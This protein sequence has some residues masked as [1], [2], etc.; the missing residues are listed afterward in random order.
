MLEPVA[1]VVLNTVLCGRSALEHAVPLHSVS[2]ITK[3]PASRPL[4]A[5]FFNPQPRR[6]VWKGKERALDETE[7]DT[8]LFDPREWTVGAGRALFPSNRRSRVLMTGSTRARVYKCPSFQKT[9]RSSSV[10]RQTSHSRLPPSRLLSHPVHSHSHSGHQ[11]RQASHIAD[12]QISE[13]PS[14]SIAVED[15]RRMMAKPE[16]SFDLNASLAAYETVES[17]Q[18]ASQ[19]TVHELVLLLERSLEH[20]EQHYGDMTPLDTLRDWG[21]RLVRIATALEHRIALHS[22][23]NYR[24]L[25]ALSRAHALMGD[26]EEA[27][28]VTKWMEK[29]LVEPEDRWR[30]VHVFRSLALAIHRYHDSARVLQLVASNWTAMGS[31]LSRWSSLNLHGKIAVHGRGFR[32][33]VQRIAS[34][35][36]NPVALLA[37]MAMTDADANHRRILGEVLIESYSYNHLP[38]S[39][40]DVHRELERQNIHIFLNLQLALVRSLVQERRMGPAKHL[41]ASIHEKSTFKYYLQTGLYLFGHVGDTIR[42]EKYYGRLSEQDWVNEE[43]VAMLMQAYATRGDSEK[44]K[45]LFDEFFPQDSQNNTRLNKPK[46]FHYS[47][48]IYS[49]ARKGDITGLNRWMDE[50]GEQSLEPDLHIYTML[51]QAF[52]SRGDLNSVATVL[53]RMRASGHPPD[54]VTYVSLISLLAHRRD[55]LGAESMYKRAIREGIVPSIPMVSALLNAHVEAGSW[56]GAIKIFDWI[57]TRPGPKIRLTIDIYNTVLKAYVLVGAPFRL[58]NRLFLRIE[59]AGDVTGVRPDAYSYAMLIQ[60]ACDAGRLD[61]AREIFEEIHERASIWESN[62]HVNVY[63]MTILMA[64]HLR[65]RD[66]T[67][68]RKI[69]DE[70]VERGITAD[71]TAYSVLL[72]SFVKGR[73]EAG[74][75][76][77]EDYIKSIILPK[78]ERPFL[79]PQYAGRLRAVTAL[80]HIYGPLLNAYARLERSEDVERTLQD[81][82]EKGGEVTLGMQTSLMDVYRRIGNYDGVEV[83]WRRIWE[84]GLDDIRQ[85]LLDDFK[86]E[87]N[88]DLSIDRLRTNLLCIPLSIYVDAMSSAGKHME[89]AAVWK[90]FQNNGLY[91]DSHNWNHLLVALLRAGEPYRAFQVAERVILPYQRHALRVKL[92]RDPNPSSPLYFEE[93]EPEEIEEVMEITTDIRTQLPKGRERMHRRNDRRLHGMLELDYESD[94]FGE[95][96]ADP[97]HKLYQI[98]PAWNVWRIHPVG[99]Q[100]LVWAYNSL[101]H[102]R[103]I[104]ALGDNSRELDPNEEWDMAEELLRKIAEDCPETI[105]FIRRASRRLRRKLG[106]RVYTTRLNSFGEPKEQRLAVG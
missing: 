75:K 43:D 15:F 61:I 106:E 4:A 73:S 65:R 36:Q 45:Q 68:A 5:G 59:E 97:L 84:L 64:A 48:A 83:C 6:A 62:V 80:E 94:T 41:F 52:A 71:A 100:S 33:E 25:C 85:S 56:R 32:L 91:F 96:F 30:T 18:G 98:S 26:T 34:Q 20:A 27:V 10:N 88:H 22:V 42:A 19:L 103:M 79:A 78:T 38:L 58:V 29:L 51:V 82:L 37:S 86:P 102:G 1:A 11:T 9:A 55:P 35:I 101:R 95:D 13:P 67:G 47:V 60:S 87:D 69:F 72:G 12:I 105:G 76:L 16:V 104:S 74:I 81:M 8:E 31:Y 44:V 53:S 70:M 92:E 63:I 89:I 99:V 14:A 3:S 40:L 90:D 17:Q 39:G 49:H 77:A 2:K 21:S 24:R 93:E 28:K 46:L 50:M 57:Q 54:G 7:R 23:I 66:T